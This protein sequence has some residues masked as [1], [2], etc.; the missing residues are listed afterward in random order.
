MF[1]AVPS[2]I[3]ALPIMTTCSKGMEKHMERQESHG[4]SSEFET[5]RSGSGV[6]DRR[7]SSHSSLSSVQTAGLPGCP[8]LFLSPAMNRSI[9]CIM[10]SMMVLDGCPISRVSGD[11]ARMSCS[12]SS[13]FFGLGKAFI[14]VNRIASRRAS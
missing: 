8:H 10:R 7:N 11:S 1:G 14:G 2:S 13:M 12:I 6:Q 4:F 3:P 9:I 5:A